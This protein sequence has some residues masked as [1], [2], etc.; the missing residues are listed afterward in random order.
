MNEDKNGGQAFPYQY[1]TEGNTWIHSN[2]MT[3]RDYFAAAAL[4]RIDLSS[5]PYDDNL[6]INAYSLADAMLRARAK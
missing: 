4:A 1:E 2:G 6:A 5:T 3:L